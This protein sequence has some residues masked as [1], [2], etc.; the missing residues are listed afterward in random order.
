[1]QLIFSFICL[2]NSAYL[3]YH[4]RESKACGN[5]DIFMYIMFFGSLIWLVYL[6]MTLILSFK[7]KGIVRLLSNM[8]WVFLFFHFAL[9]CW[10]LYLY[11]K[12]SNSCS[13]M[14]DFWV[15]IYIVIGFVFLFAV[16]CILFLGWYRNWRKQS[17]LKRNPDYDDVNHDHYNYGPMRGDR[18]DV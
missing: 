3:L 9:F 5:Y 17:Y 11:F 18:E 15:G 14:W 10:A 12:N 2:L 1:M 13:E 4:H 8:D 6:L 7:N 16:L